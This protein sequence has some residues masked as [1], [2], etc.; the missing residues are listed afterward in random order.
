MEE[1]QSKEVSLWYILNRLEAHPC[2]P[3]LNPNSIPHL[4]LTLRMEEFCET[5]GFET[6]QVIT[7]LLRL[8][9]CLIGVR[10]RVRVN[11]LIL[12]G[13]DLCTK[14]PAER[15]PGPD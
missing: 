9:F 6:G 14:S 1:R 7:N 13:R 2:Y 3:Q 8:P 10:V 15:E 5:T 11:A 4:T 12:N